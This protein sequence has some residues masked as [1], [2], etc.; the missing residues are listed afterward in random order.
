MRE[1]PGKSKTESGNNRKPTRTT[2]ICGEEEQEKRSSTYVSVCVGD[3]RD[4]MAC[5][6]RETT[7]NLK[8]KEGN[9]ARRKNKHPVEK[10]RRRERRLVNLFWLLLY[11]CTYSAIPQSTNNVTRSSGALALG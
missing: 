9:T 10:E 3:G 2:R 5:L 11:T 7:M 6:G 4:A 1:V 8:E